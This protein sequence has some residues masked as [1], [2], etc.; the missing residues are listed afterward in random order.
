MVYSRRT[1]DRL[2]Q[3]VY[4]TSVSGTYWV[5]ETNAAGCSAISAASTVTVSSF[6]DVTI[7]HPGGSTV[8]CTG[9][10]VALNAVAGAG[11]SY[12]W[13]KGGIAIAGAT[14]ATYIASLSGGYRVRVTNTIGCT[15]ETHADSV[16]TVVSSTVVVP[17]TPARFCW[18]GSSLLSTS[19]SSVGSAVSYQW[20]FNGVVI[21]GA[22]SST[23]SA[24]S[25]GTYK[26]IIT[27]P[28]GCTVS[29][30]VIPVVENP[31]PDPII[32]F[33][34]TRFHTQNYFV[35][36]QW[37]KGLTSITGATS[38][39]TLASGNANYK[40]IVTDTNGCQ[41]SSSYYVLTGWH[42]TTTVTEAVGNED[43]VKIYPNP[44]STMVHIESGEQVRAI[45]TSVDGRELMNID[46]ARDINISQLSNGVYLII[47]YNTE[48]LIL[49]KLKLV[50]TAE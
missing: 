44:A 26:C 30:N 6:P 33:D 1:S 50:K 48:N 29:T 12:Q 11:F 14:N 32:T 7:T 45:I 8:F 19:V 24:T 23:Y 17:L 31:L 46:A 13:F 35:L 22:N 16:V 47:V 36:F 20:Y 18:G 3:H 2:N 40:V 34:G 25:A 43:D 21:A 37:Y 49:K 27:V 10:S 39:N 9:G 15:D 5:V 28:G 41:S 38:S 42:G 4:T